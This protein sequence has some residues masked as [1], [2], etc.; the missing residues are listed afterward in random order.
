MKVR[1]NLL[2]FFHQFVQPSFFHPSSF[3]FHPF[4]SGPI[5]LDLIQQFVHTFTLFFDPISY[6]KNFRRARQIKRSAKLFANIRSGAGQ[7][8]E[9]QTMFLFI[10]GNCEINPR[11]LEIL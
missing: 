11:S 6:K 7:S 8:A 1:S 2:S 4:F 9:R 3:I 10:T 5:L